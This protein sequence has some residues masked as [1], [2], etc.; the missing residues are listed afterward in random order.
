[1]ILMMRA[2][3]VTRAIG[4]GVP[5]IETSLG[6]E[7]ATSGASAIWAQKSRLVRKETL[8]THFPPPPLHTGLW[9]EQ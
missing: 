9:T 7:M 2:R 5:E 4:R 8:R 6:P 3:S 1:M